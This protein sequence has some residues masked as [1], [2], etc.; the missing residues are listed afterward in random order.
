MKTTAKLGIIA[1]AGMIAL[2]QL[3]PLAFAEKPAAETAVTESSTDATA[4]IKPT[5]LLISSNDAYQA[6]RNVQAARLAIFN[7]DPDL[8][9]ELTVAASTSLD[10]AALASKD[11]VIATNDTKSN[12]DQYIPFDINMSLAEGFVQT[13][14][15]T[16]KLVEASNQFAAGDEKA[17]AE[18]LKLANI[19]VT[20]SAA[21]LPVE[22]S[23][24]HIRDAEGLLIEQKYYEA[25]LALRAL[26]N[27]I[28]IE[29]FG[30]DVLPEQGSVS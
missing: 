6:L 10:T 1:A 5:Q 22:T 16:E 13:D 26:E 12:G 18:I 28:I 29:Y 14:A 30:I 21:L 19:E 25:N 7:G 3:A 8:A 24:R 11:L 27:S 2:T 15:M 20:V 9:V 23:L 4:G 17:G